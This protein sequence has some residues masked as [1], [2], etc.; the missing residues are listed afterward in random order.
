[1]KR[2]TFLGFA[3]GGAATVPTAAKHALT[4]AQL[5]SM[6]FPRGT[7]LVGGSLSEDSASYA[8]ERAVNKPSMSKLRKFVTW[9][10]SQGTP[11]FLSSELHERT[12]QMRH[13]G[14]D[15]DLAVLR[16]MS[17]V[18]KARIQGARNRRRAW[19]VMLLRVTNN[20]SREE[21]QEMCKDRFGFEPNWWY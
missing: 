13:Y 1:M 3:L 8:L 9:I 17:P 10:R 12:M 15:P 11:D 2:R 16:S 19:N 21:F 7:E 20:K 4:E 5:G 18:N 6:G 14:F